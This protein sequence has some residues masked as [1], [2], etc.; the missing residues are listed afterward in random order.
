MNTLVS[1]RFFF[2][3]SLVFCFVLDTRFCASAVLLIE[4]SVFCVFSSLSH[5]QI[6]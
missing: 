1:E 2:S 6:P 4:E 5:W 3:S